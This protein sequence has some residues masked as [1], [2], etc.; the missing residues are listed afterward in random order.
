MERALHELPLALFTTLA[1]VGAGAFVY[2]SLAGLLLYA[3]APQLEKR[4][5]LLSIIPAGIVGVGFIA[6]VFHLAN[7]LHGIYVFSHLGVSPLS[8][9]LLAAVVFAGLMAV[10]LVLALFSKLTAL[11]RRILNLLLIGFGLVFA[12][13]MGFAYMMPT[14]ITWNTPY[15]VA[16]MLGYCLTGGSVLGA[17]VLCLAGYFKHDL[18]QGAERYMQ[19]RKLFS[20]LAIVLMLIG[21]VLG[22][23]GTFGQY[24]LVQSVHTGFVVG[25]EYAHEL[26]FAFYAFAGLFACGTLFGLLAYRKPTS[27]LYGLASFL[28]VVG[29]LSARLVFYATEISVGV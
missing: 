8:N 3:A 18:E 25:A 28:I 14:I 1:S 15:M 17:L 2:L 4:A 16:A 20:V 24:Q 22:F 21:C 26:R 19:Q 11:I 23:V 27:W 12:A 10:Y 6:S 29:V 7:P 9:E 5:D 13:S